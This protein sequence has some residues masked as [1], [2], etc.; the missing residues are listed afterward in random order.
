MCSFFKKK[1]IKVDNSYQSLY[2]NRHPKPN[3]SRY[4]V[5]PIAVPCSFINRVYRTVQL[6]LTTQ[7]SLK[8]SW[9]RAGELCL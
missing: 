4:I 6:K 3:R 1:P 9:G 8:L 5:A 7:Y 2:V